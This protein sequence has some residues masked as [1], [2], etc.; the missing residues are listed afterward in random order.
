[1]TTTTDTTT[2]HPTGTAAAGTV[3]VRRVE[4][5]D[6]DT[7]M[8]MVREIAVHEDQLQHLTVTADRWAEVLARPDV[9][10]LIARRDGAAVG[11]VSAVRR[12]HLWSD[13]DVLALDD[14]YVRE[15]ARDGG[16]GRQLMAALAA[17]YAA[18]DQLVVTWGVEPDNAAAQRFYRR[19]GATLRDKVLAG[20]SPAAY[21]D[22]VG[23]GR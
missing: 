12:I 1:M 8:E 5:R 4:P 13:R 7:V 17:G 15:H 10:V 2:N 23:A 22:V 16:V 9:V 14:L 3:V 20:W 19:L 18:P 21:A 11:Y 6:A